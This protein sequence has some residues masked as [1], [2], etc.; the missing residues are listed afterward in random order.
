[1]IRESLRFILLKGQ[2]SKSLIQKAALNEFIGMS[3]AQSKDNLMSKI[4]FKTIYGTKTHF[5][6]KETQ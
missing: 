3:M 1:M 6:P 4:A 2:A 5:N